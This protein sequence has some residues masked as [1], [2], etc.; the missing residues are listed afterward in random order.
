MAVI[1]N[2]PKIISFKLRAGTT[3]VVPINFF[4]KNQAGVS[5]PLDIS[6]LNFKVIGKLKGS[7]TL[8]LNSIFDASDLNS[9]ATGVRQGVF[10]SEAA[11]NRIIFFYDF[12]ADDDLLATAPEGEF[13]FTIWMT[14]AVG[15]NNSIAVINADCKSNYGIELL[16]SEIV[17]GDINVTCM[18][19]NVTVNCNVRI[20][21]MPTAS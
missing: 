4:T 13:E 21:Q 16:D 19:N 18:T 12:I 6:S 11:T 2:S 9:T 3:I 1:D 8:L 5:I 7:N 10:L 14:D 15:T 17:N 20:I